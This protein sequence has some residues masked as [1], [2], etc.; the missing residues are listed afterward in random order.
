VTPTGLNLRT[1]TGHIESSI[2]DLVADGLASFVHYSAGWFFESNIDHSAGVG[3]S[4][5]KERAVMPSCDC[6]SPALAKAKLLS[7]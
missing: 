2:A 1:G 5:R 4:G 6:T 7:M 3:W